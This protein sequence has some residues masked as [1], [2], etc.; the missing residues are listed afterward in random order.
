MWFLDMLGTER[1]T[2]RQSDKPTDGHAFAPV[3]EMKYI[4][5]AQ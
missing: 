5:N 4:W 1:Q 3:S 2:E